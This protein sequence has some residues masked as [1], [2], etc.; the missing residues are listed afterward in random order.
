MNKM[1]FPNTLI[2][3]YRSYN[4]LLLNEDVKAEYPIATAQPIMTGM[5]KFDNYLICGSQNGDLH[6][7]K[8]S[9]LY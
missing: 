4:N 2:A 9:C 1:N 3:N 7:V 6:F 5:T 8:T